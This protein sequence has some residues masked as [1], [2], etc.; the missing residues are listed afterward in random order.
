M[1]SV[2]L[3]LAF[4]LLLAIGFAGAYTLAYALRREARGLDQ[5]GYLLYPLFLLV[6]LGPALV[7]AV[8]GGG[9]W[10]FGACPPLIARLTTGPALITGAVI[11]VGVAFV[12]FQAEI[13]VGR[14]LARRANRLSTAGTAVMEGRAG[15]LAGSAGRSL[16]TILSV[17]LLVVLAEEFLWRGYLPATLRQRLGVA[18]PWTLA[19]AVVSFG[20][21]HYYF[22]LRT[23]TSRTIAGLVW[24][25]LAT[26]TDS[27]WIPVVSHYAFDCLAWRSLRR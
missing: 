27:L 4:P 21:N 11:A 17:D 16:A 20:L 8:R 2:N 14:W 5:A 19:I 22:G 3:I 10:D 7:D 6:P 12:L 13:A 23:V 9:L 26:A 24:G 18:A 1:L 25:L 15:R